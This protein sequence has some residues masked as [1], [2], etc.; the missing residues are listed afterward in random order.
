MIDC[1]NTDILELTW[2]WLWLLLGCLIAGPVGYA[3]G[4]RK[5]RRSL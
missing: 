4:K 2:A 3:F 5:K 1:E